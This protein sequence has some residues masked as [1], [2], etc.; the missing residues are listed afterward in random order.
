M[1]NVTTFPNDHEEL[2]SV[3]NSTYHDDSVG[4]DFFSQGDDDDDDDE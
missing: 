1:K 4:E 3:R 2:V